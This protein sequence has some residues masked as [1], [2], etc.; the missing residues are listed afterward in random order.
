MTDNPSG[1]SPRPSSSAA[2][3]TSLTKVLMVPSPSSPS[4]PSRGT[5]GPGTSAVAA[6]NVGSNM[7]SGITSVAISPDSRYVAAGSLDTVVRIWDVVTGQLLEQLRGHRD[8]VYSVAFTPDGR[9]LVSGSL[10]K[11]LKGWD[12]SAVVSGGS[13]KGKGEGKM[14]VGGAGSP[15]TCTMDFAGHKVSRAVFVEF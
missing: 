2:Q 11:T 3:K 9:G 12:V 14:V 15:S 13:G 10:D 8:S 7:D 1:S 5:T 4:A 6:L